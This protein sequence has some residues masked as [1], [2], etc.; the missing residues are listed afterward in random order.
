MEKDF[1]LL[2]PGKYRDSDNSFL[3]NRQIS[4]DLE[5]D[6]IFSVFFYRSREYYKMEQIFSRISTVPEVINF[7]LDVFEDF[8]NN[9]GLVRIFTDIINNIKV[10]SARKSQAVGKDDIVY[11]VISRLGELEIYLKCIE[12][13][14]EVFGDS[15][16]NIR[17]AGLK[18]LRKKTEEIRS[19][20]IYSILK[21]TLP[22]LQARFKGIKSI[23]VGINLDFNRLPYQATLLS[24]NTEKYTEKT[25]GVLKKLLKEKVGEFEGLG[26]LY[27]APSRLDNLFENG[28]VSPTLVPLFREL[29]EILK[30]TVNPVYKALQQYSSINIFFLIRLESDISFYLKGIEIIKKLQ[31]TGLP[32]C[33]PSILPQGK[34]TFI[35]RDSYNLNLVLLKGAEN[36]KERNSRIV[37]NDI[38]MDDNGRVFIVTGPNRGGKTIFLQSVGHTAILAQL[39]FYVPA[40]KAELSPVSGIFTHF[41]TQENIE[42]GTGRLGDEA[43]RFGDIFSM[44]DRNCLCLFN[45]SLSSTNATEGYYIAKD[46]IKVLME[47]GCRTVYTTHLHELAGAVENLNKECSTGEKAV[48]LVSQIIENSKG[49]ERTFKIVPGPP[50]GQSYAREIAQ[51]YG[52]DYDQLKSRLNRE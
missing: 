52:I 9:P 42:R 36:R 38:S 18:E 51:K 5:L 12:N 28:P 30:K 37:M 7:R 40:E 2:C 11:I 15:S 21:E 22:D 27:E 6:K 31:N 8:Y 35:C 10:V 13:L 41:Q 50:V 17:S 39:G 48:S 47:A 49:I 14:A 34:R 16:I 25:Q 43:E 1:S 20:E 46:I 29:N 23:S 33:R 44:L 4:D 3:Y 45:E 24:V 26:R 32:V 19:E